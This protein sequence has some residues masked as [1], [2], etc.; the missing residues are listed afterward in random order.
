MS[1]QYARTHPCSGVDTARVPF[2]K[3]DQFSDGHADSGKQPNLFSVFAVRTSS[4]VSPGPDTCTCSDAAR[5]RANTALA[6]ADPGTRTAGTHPCANAALTYA[7]PG[8]RTAGAH[9]CPRAG[10]TAAAPTVKLRS[11]V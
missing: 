3:A 4:S 7:D 1:G 2:M 9:P 6:C 10:T 8:T 5:T 11:R